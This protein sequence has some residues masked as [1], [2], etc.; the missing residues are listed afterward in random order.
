MGVVCQF[1][2][3]STDSQPAWTSVGHI[4]GILNACECGAS[5][6]AAIV[7]ALFLGWTT[8][9]VSS[10]PPFSPW[11]LFLFLFFL[12]FTHLLKKNLCLSAYEVLIQVLLFYSILLPTWGKCVCLAISSTFLQL[13]YVTWVS[14]SWRIPTQPS[15]CRWRQCFSLGQG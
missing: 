15:Q 2:V 11:H 1:S 9:P 6:V 8:G 5:W 10:V 14:F 3:V 12:S 13:Q 4:P 7:R